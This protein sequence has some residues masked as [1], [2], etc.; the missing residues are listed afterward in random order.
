MASDPAPG[1]SAAVRVLGAAGGIAAVIGVVL[2]YLGPT[3]LANVMVGL[4]ALLIAATLLVGA[5]LAH[6]LYLVRVELWKARGPARSSSSPL[7]A[8]EEGP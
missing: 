2:I 3:G 8:E 4:G 5:V 6:G 1:K 7:S